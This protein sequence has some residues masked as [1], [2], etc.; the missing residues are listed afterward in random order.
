[1]LKLR[2]RSTS[3]GDGKVE[4]IPPDKKNDA[5]SAAFKLQPGDWQEISV[6]IPAEGPLGILRVYLPAQK[7]PVE[8]EW[9]STGKPKRWKF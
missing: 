8:I 3:G 1:V 2:A 4:W 7:Q 9:K 6:S 5:K